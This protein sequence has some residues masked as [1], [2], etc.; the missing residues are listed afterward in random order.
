MGPGAGAGEHEV[1]ARQVE[2]LDRRRVE[3]QQRPEGPRAGARLLQEAGVDVALGEA[4]L[5][6]G[7]VVD[8]REHVGLG[9]EIADRAEDPLGSAQVEQ[10]VVNKGNPPRC[11]SLHGREAYVPARRG[12]TVSHAG[13]GHRARLLE[14]PP[15]PTRIPALFAVLALLA[16][17]SSALAQSAGDDQYTNPVPQSQAPSSNGS[18]GGSGSGS[19]NGSGSG[20]APRAPPPARGRPRR[21]TTRP[22]RA[23]RP[24]TPDPPPAT[25]PTTRRHASQHR[26]AARSARRPRP[27]VH[28]L[29]PPPAAR[30]R[31]P[32]SGP[33]RD[34]RGR[35]PGLLARGPRRAPAL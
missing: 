15:M 14:I 32:G 18:G 19:G 3:G 11:S 5:G 29:G 2:R 17:P 7:L 12:S 22:P 1:V 24:R 31:G 34:A 33:L 26:P 20:S 10:E 21:P 8:R 4:A 16:V 35:R 9:V 27:A 28:L 6:A 13:E 30:Q 23:P 25:A